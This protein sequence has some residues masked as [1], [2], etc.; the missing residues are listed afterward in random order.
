MIIILVRDF[1]ECR[2]TGVYSERKDSWPQTF[3]LHGRLVRHNAV[4]C[5]VLPLRR[6]RV[7]GLLPR[8]LSRC[9]P[10]CTPRLCLVPPLLV[11]RRGLESHDPE[12]VR[13]ECHITL[14][15]GS[16]RQQ[17]GRRGP[18]A[19]CGHSAVDRYKI[20]NFSRFGTQMT[21]LF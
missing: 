12:W 3:C 14:S 18:R 7:V 10:G 20:A 21:D 8:R 1:S 13:G 6:G 4:D 9:F 5:C 19:C 17:A 15:V 16:Q 2:T 11:P